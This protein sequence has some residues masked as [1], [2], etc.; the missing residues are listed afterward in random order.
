MPLLTALSA[1]DPAEKKL[2]IWGP[3]SIGRPAITESARQ[4]EVVQHSL[5]FAPEVDCSSSTTVKMFAVPGWSVSASSLVTQTAPE[6]EP[7]GP[8]I[9]KAV[10]GANAEIPNA[11]KRKR[12]G[13]SEELEEKVTRKNIGDMWRKHVEGEELPPPE[14][15]PKQ[16]QAKD[17]TKKVE[18]ENGGGDAA[19]GSTTATGDS[20]NGPS[21]KR[22]T[23]K[24]KKREKA[25][26][27][28]KAASGGAT[29][30][31]ED[32]ATAPSETAAPAAPKLTAL[33]ASMRAK[34]LSSRFRHLNETLY[35]TPSSHALKLFTDSP[36][37]FSEYH[38]G[39]ARQVEESWPENPVVGYINAIKTRGAIKPAKANPKAVLDRSA[40]NEPLP[41]RPSGLCT[42]ADLGCGD[43][44]LAKDLRKAKMRD[45][46]VNSYDLFSDGQYITKADIANLPLADGSVDLTIFCLS[47]MGTNWIDFVEEAWRILR[48]DGRGECWVSEVKSRFGKVKRKGGIGTIR[49]NTNPNNTSAQKGGKPPRKT[50]APAAD[51]ELFAEDH[52][53][54]NDETDISAFVE[55]FKARGFVLRPDS[56][57]LSNKMFVR[58]E[59]VKVAGVAPLRGKYAGQITGPKALNQK[60]AEK[61][62]G[63]VDGKRGFGGGPAVSKFGNRFGG[64]KTK[65]VEETVADA[66]VLAEEAKV[67]KPCVYK[68]R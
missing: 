49:P 5:P 37:L 39:F 25:A 3:E 38:T 46:R 42:I 31:N 62:D 16:K 27:K 35:T 7:Q 20:A 10:T 36:E 53:Q 4:L 60:A 58:M 43:A 41:R 40:A 56:V 33:Q 24:E 67:L 11:K 18:Q 47:L 44:Q 57:D 28:A 50:E 19:P 15:K 1:G 34:L 54:S 52:A 65:F 29:D 55:V 26:A 30:D 32:A 14:R 63:K 45:I 21:K 13:R 48:G 66:K 23:L 22:K 12:G 2:P 6:K 64:P 51:E 17:K 8:K 61:G 9:P 68:I 59:F